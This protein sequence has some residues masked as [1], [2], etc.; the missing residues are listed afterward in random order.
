MELV[1][2]YVML[3]HMQHI[4][5]VTWLSLAKQAVLQDPK[6]CDGLAGLVE[7][8]VPVCWGRWKPGPPGPHEGGVQVP[9]RV[10]PLRG[11]ARWE[12]MPPSCQV[13]SILKE[14]FEGAT[15]VYLE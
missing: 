11:A 3:I 6:G 13:C 8:Q 9:G 5:A 15:E 1:W 2:L 14:K 7:E 10:G 12:V 4:T